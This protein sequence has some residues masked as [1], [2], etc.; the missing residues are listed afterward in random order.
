MGAGKTVKLMDMVCVR[1]PKDKVHTLAL[2]TMDSRSPE[3]I[4]GRVGAPMKVNGRTGNAMVWGWSPEAAGYTGGN[5]RKD[6]KVATGCA[7]LQHRTPNTRVPGQMAFRMDM[8]QKRT[9]MEE[10]F[11]DSG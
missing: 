4:F 2:G 5:G 10:R 11:K 7:N 3:S 9:L 6:S 8:A 1:D